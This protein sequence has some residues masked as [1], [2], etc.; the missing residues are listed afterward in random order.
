[1]K[2]YET[3]YEEYI[4]AVEEY[5]LHP[6]FE[7]LINSSPK[8]ISQFGNLIIYGPS[9]VGKY[10]LMLN[11]IKKYSPSELKYDKKMTLQ[12]EKQQYIYRISDIHYEIDMSLL[13]CNSK[14]LW[15]EIFL[16][17]VD[18]VSV[19]AEKVGII[20][21]KNFHGIHNELL[22]IFYSYIQQYNHPQLNFQIKFILLTEQLSFLPNN[23]LNTCYTVHVKRP[24]KSQYVEMVSGKG[25]R[26]YITQSSLNCS[27]LQKFQNKISS[28][29]T[30]QPESREQVESFMSEMGEVNGILNAKEVRSFSLYADETKDIPTDIFNTICNSII[31]E[32]NDPSR[33]VIA[34]FRDTLYDILI[35]N[36]DAIEC[37]WHVLMH[38]VEEKR[39][40]S[41]DLGLILERTYPF[42]KYY[43][44]NYRPIYHL[45]SIFVYIITKLYGYEECLNH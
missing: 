30:K 32:M 3:H 24:D 39:L 42:L 10:S 28:P 8:N 40:S 27:P 9:G 41:E 34:E 5:N 45:E 16:Q 12:T 33:L 15:H 20:V 37:V 23:I 18:I 13:G 21:C 31:K 17:I 14:I 25:T 11:M 2:F 29:K 43:N 4:N 6:E 22:D 7:A 35:Y 1:M 36:L 26:R 38:F 44:N 19:K